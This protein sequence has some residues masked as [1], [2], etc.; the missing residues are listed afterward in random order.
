MNLKELQDLVTKREIETL[1]EMTARKVVR[2]C[3]SESTAGRQTPS[4][5]LCSEIERIPFKVLV[6]MALFFQNSTSEILKKALT[7]SKGREDLLRDFLRDLGVGLDRSMKRARDDNQELRVTLLRILWLDGFNIFLPARKQN[8]LATWPPLNRWNGR[9][10]WQ[11]LK[12]T[13][14]P[15]LD[16]RTYRQRVSR[17][18]LYQLKPILV[19]KLEI[20]PHTITITYT[21]AGELWRRDLAGAVTRNGKKMFHDMETLKRLNAANGSGKIGKNSRGGIKAARVAGDPADLYS[22]A[23]ARHAMP[24]D[25]IQ[26]KRAR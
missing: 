12:L 6:R 24:L 25:R 10:A 14:E 23:Q 26:P 4:E 8:R 5:Q 9:A 17:L 22:I 1:Y 2:R 11:L 16:E 3:A 18:R 21:P 15:G 13:L 19:Q 20:S 7:L